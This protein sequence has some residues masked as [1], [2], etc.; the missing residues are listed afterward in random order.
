M[1]DV[2]YDADVFDRSTIERW[3]GH[4]STLAAALARDMTTEISKLPML[5]PRKEVG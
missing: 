3:I 5:L 4:F 1:I 2:D